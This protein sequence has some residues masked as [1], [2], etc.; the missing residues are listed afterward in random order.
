[1]KSKRFVLRAV[2]GLF[3][4]MLAGMTLTGCSDKTDI[5]GVQKSDDKYILTISEPG[6]NMGYLPLYIAQNEGYFAEEKLEVTYLTGGGGAHVTAVISGDSYAVVGS[7]DS[8]E[9]AAS[10]SDIQFV[11]ISNMVTK[12]NVQLSAS[13][14]VPNYEG[15]TEISPDNKELINYLLTCNGSEPATIAAGRY[16]GTPNVMVRYLLAKLGFTPAVGDTSTYNYDSNGVSG[17]IHILDTADSAALSSAMTTGSCQLGVPS[18]PSLT[19]GVEA[20]W[21]YEPFLDFCD[22]GDFAYSV[23]STTEKNLSTDEGKEI[24]Q[25]FCN[26]MVKT[27]AKVDLAADEYLSGTT[28]ENYE[29]LL[30]CAKA[31]FGSSYS[32]ELLDKMLK[33][34]LASG[35]WSANGFVTQEA[36]DLDMGVMKECGIYDGAYSY[37]KSVNMSFIN[38]ANK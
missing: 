24:A 31:E 1:M 8:N 27:L 30:S 14:A 29:W 15:S 38:E 36:L 5:S 33:R 26:A 23:I 9:A 20:G 12:A 11:T 21:W 37:D 34:S 10:G 6:H 16:G 2:A 25:G 22:M 19:E 7:V 4:V 13:T 17:T 35:L 32:D 28:G 3:S 18:D